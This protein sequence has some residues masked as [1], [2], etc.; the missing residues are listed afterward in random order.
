[1]ATSHAPHQHECGRHPRHRLFRPGTRRPLATRGNHY[2]DILDGIFSSDEYGR[3]HGSTNAGYVAGLYQDILGRPA[4]PGEVNGWLA[5]LGSPA[6]RHGVVNGF[7][8][9]DEY[10]LRVLGQE[11]KDYLA[12]NLSK[13]EG[14]FWLNAVKHGTDLDDVLA[15]VISSEEYFHRMRS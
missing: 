9:S 1:M 10:R 3:K 14:N 13:P 11:Y 6:G 12:R 4:T 7:L 15:A 5:G 8:S 2:K